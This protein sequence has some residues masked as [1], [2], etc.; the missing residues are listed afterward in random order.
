[1]PRAG[2]AG[3]TLGVRTVR[4]LECL[5]GLAAWPRQ[6]LSAAI[7]KQIDQMK[8]QYAESLDSTVP[9]LARMAEPQGSSDP[10]SL[11]SGSAESSA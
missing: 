11:F 7:F 3:R 8:F 1:M 9:L 6:Y 2:R 4:T 10:V 5:T